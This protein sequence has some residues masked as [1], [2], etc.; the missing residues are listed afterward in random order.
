ME[1]V[2]DGDNVLNI[3]LEAIDNLETFNFS[4]ALPDYNVPSLVPEPQINLDFNVTPLG[5]P[6]VFG[7]I[8][9]FDLVHDVDTSGLP[10]ISTV[11]IPEFSPTPLT[12]QIPDAPIP[13]NI[14]RP[15][16]APAAPVLTF[17]DEITITLPDSPQLTTLT[18]PAAPSITI[19]DFDPVFPTFTEQNIDTRIDWTE[20]TYNQEILDDVLTQ[21]TTF[22]AGGSGIDPDV[23]NSIFARSR[24]REDRTVRQQE[25]QATEEWAGKGYTAP[26]GMLVKRIDNI[27]EEG[28]LKKLGLNREQTIKVFDTEIENLRFAVQQGIEAERLFVQLFL[29]K[30]ERLFEVERLVVQWRIELYNLAVT[31]FRAK[32]DEVSIR[33]RVYEVQVQAALVD[34]EVFKALIDAE[35]VKAQVN[36]AIIES[37]KAEIE[38]REALVAVYEAQVRA[39]GVRADVFATQVNAYR[40][41]VQAYG[42]EVAADTN[43]FEA[44]ATRIRGEV[45]KAS[46]L[47]SEA[48]AYQAEIQGIETGVNAEVAALQGEVAAIETE[49]RNF[50][51]Q[52]RG[53][54]GRSQNQLAAIQGNVAGHG[55][56]VNRKNLEISAEESA[57]RV[58]VAAID[59]TNRVNIEQHRSAIQEYSAKLEA[60]IEEVRLR[61]SAITSA[62]ELSSTIAAG[63][64][65]AA[66]VGATIS[67]SGGLSAT[68]SDG[69]SFSYSDSTQC[70]T[71]NSS[72]INF[73]STTEPN[74]A[75]P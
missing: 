61:V 14:Q 24:D 31:V 5:D 43:R 57:D 50:E 13:E 48:R 56:D 59:A 16:S 11:D 71:L 4:T 52:V 21:I 26:P 42:T 45:G 38:A 40:A 58:E 29:A 15:D 70:S 27:R 22:F 8:D 28:T 67:G 20:P 68:G 37:Y 53:Y 23:E 64:L 60:L 55:I 49:I 17:P 33:A 44:Y 74:V 36:L 19:P 6:T 63:A 30:V 9:P 47:E 39:V 66:H 72:S 1:I 12:I 3:A 7:V 54:I 41:E 75:C 34:I 32:M 46:I 2:G 10:T 51:S 65:A 35:Q 73:E 25:Q 69:V 62:G 18:I